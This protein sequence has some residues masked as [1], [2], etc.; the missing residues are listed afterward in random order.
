MSAFQEELGVPE[1]AHAR[2]PLLRALLLKGSRRDIQVKK[3]FAA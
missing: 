1:P 2:F 3:R